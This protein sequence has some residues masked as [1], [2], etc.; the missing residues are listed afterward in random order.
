MATILEDA[1]EPAAA[2]G[3]E[4][5]LAPKG[6][7]AANPV[8]TRKNSRR[9]IE[10]MRFSFFVKTLFLPASGFAPAVAL[11]CRRDGYG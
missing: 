10:S 3:V 1:M 5:T 11:S 2:T 4:R 6:T 8:P 7:A 9:L